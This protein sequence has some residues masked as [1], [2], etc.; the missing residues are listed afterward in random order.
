MNRSD[1]CQHFL[2]L[3]DFL[4]IMP[5]YDDDLTAAETLRKIGIPAVIVH[6]SSDGEGIVCSTN[7][8]NLINHVTFVAKAKAGSQT[9]LLSSLSG[10]L[11]DLISRGFTNVP[12]PGSDMTLDQVQRILGPCF[13]RMSAVAQTPTPVP[14]PIPVQPPPNTLSPLVL[15][16][17][18]LAQFIQE[19]RIHSC[20]AVTLDQLEQSLQTLSV[21]L[22]LDL[23]F[24]VNAPPHPTY[25]TLSSG[26]G[27]SAM[28]DDYGYV[29]SS[30]F[31]G[32][33]PPHARPLDMNGRVTPSFEIESPE[34][35]LLSPTDYSSPV[36]LTQS[37]TE[38]RVPTSSSGKLSPN[39]H[40][41]SPSQ[42]Q[43]SPAQSR[44]NSPSSSDAT[45]SPHS[46]HSSPGQ[47]RRPPDFTRTP[48]YQQ[49][50]RFRGALEGSN[51]FFN[52]AKSRS[53]EFVPHPPSED[54]AM[55]PSPLQ[56]DPRLTA[57]A[58]IPME[59]YGG[60]FPGAPQQPNPFFYD[61]SETSFLESLSQA[62]P[63]PNDFS[64]LYTG[65]K[66]RRL[67]SSQADFLSPP[68]M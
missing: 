40:F 21:G 54:Y 38:Y 60:D 53:S 56:A 19:T 31:Q 55:G 15:H 49:L 39:G 7:D 17:Q 44:R 12:L 20:S 11:S 25:Q 67:N 41:P 51:P 50:G 18:L 22:E 26:Q 66:R 32:Q 23:P 46:F 62:G 3:K 6:F 29:R 14:P 4:G 34:G 48:P 30:P 63:D 33:S 9:Q 5:Q 27:D 64:S 61:F 59:M 10:Y 2:A 13:S 16:C 68:H 43:I 58:N 45:S 24:M 57:S 28:A 36:S 47:S 35:F 42:I 8:G 37:G 52:F 65:G 1:D